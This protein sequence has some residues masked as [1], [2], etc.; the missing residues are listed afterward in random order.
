[1]LLGTEITRLAGKRHLEGIEIRD[2][3]T[4]PVREV[5]TTAV[6]AFIGAR[7]HTDWLPEDIEADPSGFIRTGP[8]VSNR[9]AGWEHRQPYFL[10]TSRPGVFAA[11][12]VC[13]GS[14][15]RVASAVGEGAMV[16]AFVHDYLHNA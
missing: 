14:M 9:A 13:Q 3:R 7:P 12:D 10:E 8:A 5:E 15:K 6:F 11:G 4:G 2:N 1:M 16:V